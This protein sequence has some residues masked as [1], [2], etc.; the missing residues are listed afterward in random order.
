M[1]TPDVSTAATTTLADARRR[2]TIEQIL[3]SARQLVMAR[4][5][6][7]TMDEIAEGVG[8]ARRTL[9]RHFETRERLLA[10]ALEA[11]IQ[12]YGELLP[13]LAGDWREWLRHLCEA[14]HRM[15]AG[16][17]PGYWELT[18]RSDLPTEI[19]AVEQRRHAQR[20]QAVTR[21]ARTLWTEA[22]GP[23]D[24][25]SRVLADVCA[26]LSPRFTAAVIVDAAATWRV[27]ADLANDAIRTTIDTSIL[28]LQI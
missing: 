17:G 6:D 14:V 21:I 10:Q 9:F 11:G 13:E 12:R 8:V 25:P 24:T 20:Q 7:V 5:L 3:I 16:Y 23:G 2:A 18:S 15:Q 27:A 22:G 26:H 28:D 4:G 1:G 19:A